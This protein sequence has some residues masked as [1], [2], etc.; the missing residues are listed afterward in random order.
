MPGPPLQ[1]YGQIASPT[2]RR[3]GDRAA[4]EFPSCRAYQQYLPHLEE[5][6]RPLGHSLSWKAA[7][8]LAKGL[9]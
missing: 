8:G 7:K 2:V 9:G 6:C 3:S 1:N 4:F 5:A